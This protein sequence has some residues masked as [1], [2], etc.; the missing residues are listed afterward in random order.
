VFELMPSSLGHWSETV[1]HNFDGID[2][3][4]PNGWLVFDSSGNL[5]GTAANGGAHYGGTAFELT[6]GSGGWI[7]TTL[8]DFCSEGNGQCTD[9]G[10][11]EAGMVLDKAGNLYGTARAGT[12]GAGV[13]FEMTPN[14]GTA[15]TE[16]VLYGFCAKPGCKDGAGPYAGLIWDAAGNLYGTTISGGSFGG[17][18]A[19]ELARGTGGKWKEHL[20]HNFGSFQFD[21]VRLLAPLIF[22][23]SGTLYGTAGRGGKYSCT[24]GE[25]GAVFKLT[26]LQSGQWKETVLYSF[27]PGGSGA[28]PSSGV[29]LD[30]QGNLYGTTGGGGIGSCAEGCGVVYK[31]AP[32]Q[33][34]N[35][36]YTVLHRF[37]GPDGAIPGGGLILDNKGNLYGTTELG[38]TGTLGVVFEITP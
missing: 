4:A 21:G 14:T 28:Y 31:L 10:G 25:C 5:Y 12:Y 8:Y 6:P 18:T 20:L 9:G 30:S 29:V 15:W 11:P 2:G 1:V 16:S 17:G 19:F 13:V 24:G 33:G 26:R 37:T 34:G 36:K 27:K 22:D 3:E 32:G 38:G 23:K 7:E 35:W